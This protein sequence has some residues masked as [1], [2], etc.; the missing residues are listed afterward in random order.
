MVDK[1]D[2]II[3]SLEVE[4][5]GLYLAYGEISKRYKEIRHENNLLTQKLKEQDETRGNKRKDLGVGKPGLSGSSDPGSC[6]G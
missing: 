3:A 2:A 1:K 5:D 4:N 6:R